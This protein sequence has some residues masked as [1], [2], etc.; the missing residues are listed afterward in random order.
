MFA[1]DQH[2]LEATGRWTDEGY[3]SALIT[4]VRTRRSAPRT[5]GSWMALRE[6]GLVTG[7]VSG[8]CIEDD[9]ISKVHSADM[10]SSV[11]FLLTYGVTQD[12]ARR[13]GLPCGATMELMV[14]HS[15]DPVG[16]ATLKACVA[17][18][19]V[20]RRRVVAGE[21]TARGRAQ[22]CAGTH[23]RSSRFCKVMNSYCKLGSAF[24][25][26]SGVSGRAYFHQEHLLY[27]A[28]NLVSCS[29]LP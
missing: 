5:P 19:R 26:T 22:D 21:Q 13:Y 15:P 11:P 28:A 17:E 9:L 2:V 12:E 24:L 4:V 18:G 7:S 14:E 16:L 20:I 3:A 1:T 8:S 10:H 6:D 29:E 27:A 25:C 23:V